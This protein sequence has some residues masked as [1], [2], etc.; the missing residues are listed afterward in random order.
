ADSLSDYPAR[1]EWFLLPMFQLRHFFHGA[2]EFWGTS[3]VPAA[4]AG[5]LA[6][7]PWID[8]PGRSR[9][10]GGGPLLR[11]FA[12]AMPVSPVAR[13]HDA[14]DKNYVKSR[15]AADARAAAAIQLAK[16]GVPPAGALSMVQNDPEMRGRELFEKHCASC[17]VLADLGDAEKSTATKLDG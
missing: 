17:H 13:V 7:L 1:P 8:R 9:A 14:H 15:R 5:F 3:L 2:M 16:N 12:A 10:V 4:A 11:I 6:L